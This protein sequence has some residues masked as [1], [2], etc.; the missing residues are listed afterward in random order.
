MMMSGDR[1]RATLPVIGPAKGDGDTMKGDE[2][3]EASVIVRTFNSASSLSRCIETL[4]QQSIAC[5]V[6]V[7]DSGSS[8]DTLSIS[9]RTA[10]QVLQL[11]RAS[12]SYGRALNVGAAAASSEYCFALSSHCWAENPRWIEQSI[13][14]YARPDVAATNGASRGPV[15]V[16]FEGIYYQTLDD[17]YQNPHWGFSNHGS[18]WRRSVWEDIKFDEHMPTAED[19]EWSWRV[20]RQGYKIAYRP[21]LAIGAPHRRAF[22]LRAL[23]SRAYNETAA[24]GRIARLPRYGFSDVVADLVEY[25]RAD[26]RRVLHPGRPAFR[27]AEIVPRWRATH[28]SRRRTDEYLYDWEHRSDQTTPTVSTG[29]QGR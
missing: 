19:K 8:D 23:Y 13:E 16:P 3:L 5:E 15:G 27:L 25:I 26:P 1:R 22:G 20:L 21:E 11:P 9:R 18:S 24:L 12:F 17:V 14:C 4:R 6:I 29:A 7:V 10:D 28:M 2:P